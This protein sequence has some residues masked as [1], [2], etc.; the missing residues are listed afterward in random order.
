LLDHAP[1]DQ[2]SGKLLLEPVCLILD[3]S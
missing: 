1:S 2:L 3:I